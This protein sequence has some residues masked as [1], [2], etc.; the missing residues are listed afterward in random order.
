MHTYSLE[1]CDKK[2]FIFEFSFE[3]EVENNEITSRYVSYRL[4]RK[5]KPEEVFTWNGN[6]ST[7]ETEFF[8]LSFPDK[9]NIKGEMCLYKNNGSDYIF[10]NASYCFDLENHFEG[11][12][13]KIPSK[14]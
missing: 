8:I 5:D 1:S 6:L 13:L 2:Q 4:L 9:I 7:H 10:I 12:I 11:N 14:K 3:E